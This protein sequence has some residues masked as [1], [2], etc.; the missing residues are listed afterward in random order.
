MVTK[1]Y[2][3]Y[4]PNIIIIGSITLLFSACSHKNPQTP[5]PK[6]VSVTILPK[7]KAPLLKSLNKTNK[8][9]ANKSAFYPLNLPTD[10]FAARLFLIDNATTS[11]DV[12]YYIY[13]DDHIGKV[14]TAHLFKAAKRGVKVR[15][16]VDDMITS[17]RDEEWEKLTLHP[18]IELRLFNPNRLRTSF[19]NIALLLDVNRLGRR[20]HNKALIAD[21]SAAIIGGRNIGNVYFASSKETLFL[22]YDVLVIGKVI[23][24]IYKAFDIY[25]NSKEAVPSKEVFTYD[26]PKLTLAIKKDLENEL[27][28]FR[29]STIGKAIINSDFNKRIAHKNLTLIV[30]E[31]A[32]FYY[33]LPAKVNT[34]ENDDSTHIS[35]Q[36]SEDLKHVRDDLVIISPY[37]IPSDEMMVRLKDLRKKGVEVTIITNSLASTDVLLVY[38]AYKNSIKELVKMGVNLYE[39][40]PHSFKKFFRTKEWANHQAL[41]LH[42]K[43]MIIDSNRMGIGSA[44][45]DPRSDKLNTEIFMV[46]SSKEL[47]KEQRERLAE[48][49]NLKNLYKLSWGKYPNEFD[50]E[51]VT[52]YGPIW[53]TIED[54][55][56]KTYYAPPHTGFW[57]K[58]GTDVSSLLPIKGYL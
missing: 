27:K 20:M 39:I 30:A 14:F 5:V 16:L 18:N 36:I 50:D 49:V 7:G 37:F 40:K 11:L 41:S 25:W 8:K 53:H 22:D 28:A 32:D 24:D 52:R 26:D 46:V 13:E 17:G 54:G 38:G 6:Q 51:E 15:I 4:L 35:S 1:Q 45:M 21:G 23:P 19:R 56:E 34:D 10:A 31:R 3:R 57:K 12:Q 43:M 44:N 58:L 48:A 9:L 55:K 47:A 42:T 2:F 29:S 33:D